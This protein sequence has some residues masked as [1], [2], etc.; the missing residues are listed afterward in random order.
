MLKILFAVCYIFAMSFLIPNEGYALIKKKAS[1]YG[2]DFFGKRTANGETY[3][4][5]DMTAA[6]KTLPF[7]TK[8]KVTNLENGKKVIVRINDRGPYVEGR[9]IDLSIAAA[10][11]LDMIKDGVAQVKI[12]VLS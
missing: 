7:G 2:M 8:V 9:N 12:E 6:H 1:Y 10:K 4:P 5:Y 3:N 11:Q